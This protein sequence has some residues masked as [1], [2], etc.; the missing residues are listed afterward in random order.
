MKL[1]IKKLT[2]AVFAIAI[3]A[4]LFS[5]CK[6]DKKDV[7]VDLTKRATA[8]LSGANETPTIESTGTGTVAIA[9]DPISKII[10]YKTTWQLGSSTATT[11][12][13]HFHG[14]ADGS[15]L[16]SSP[17]IIG[18]TGFSKMNSGEF[19][20]TTRALTLDEE[21]QFL[22]GKWYFNIH[23]STYPGGELRANIKF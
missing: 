14:A 12:N 3:T 13:M 19:S 11:L 6:K 21:S 23:S 15:D 16:K 9:Y 2:T 8:Q 5:A 4:L 17:V 1:T 7:P 18:I 20:G 10:T 22:S